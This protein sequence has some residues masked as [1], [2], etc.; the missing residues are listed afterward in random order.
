MLQEQALKMQGKTVK[1]GNKTMIEPKYGMYKSHASSSG[2]HN[3]Y[4]LPEAHSNDMSSSR[5]A[6]TKKI[7]PQEI[8]YR[9]NNGRGQRS[10]GMYRDMDSILILEL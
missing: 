5:Q 2:N 7:S 9:R 3:H 8:Q 1:F 10:F 4:K 6:D